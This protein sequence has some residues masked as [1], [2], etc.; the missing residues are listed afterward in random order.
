MI[1]ALSYWIHIGALAFCSGVSCRAWYSTASLCADGAIDLDRTERFLTAIVALSPIVLI[2][3]L[4]IP[5][6][7]CTKIA[8]HIVW[9]LVV[10]CITSAGIAM[11]VFRY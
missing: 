7:H 4:S 8:L 11:L 1:A 5:L 10:G 2:L 9:A 3:R 6:M